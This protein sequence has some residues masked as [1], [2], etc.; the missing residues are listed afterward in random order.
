MLVLVTLL[1]LHTPALSARDAL[2]AGIAEEARA[3]LGLD[4]TAEITVT[5]LESADPEA[6]ARGSRLVSFEL[7]SKGRPVGWTT[8]K[9]T[10]ERRK[11]R[12]EHWVKAEVVAKVPT[13]VATRSLER[14]DVISEDDVE[15]AL[16]PLG[17][18][19]GPAPRRERV[20]GGRVRTSVE[21]GAPVVERAVERPEVV[22]RG[23]NVV[24]IVAGEAFA[25]RAPA[26]ALEGG[27]VGDEIAV[28]VKLGKRVVR[29]VVTGPGEVEVR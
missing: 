28:R 9:V 4:E 12:A 16:A 18:D 8:V 10:V 21:K 22:N 13:L 2:V 15:V 29:G 11:V 26:E 1:C 14:G 25:V 5:R 7:A 27:A 17:F 20:V 19:R 6:L 3:R 23:A 24:A